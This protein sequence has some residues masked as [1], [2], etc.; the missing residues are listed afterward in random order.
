MTSK[1]GP[2]FADEHGTSVVCQLCQLIALRMSTETA[3]DLWL[4]LRLEMF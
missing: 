3:T 1:P 2:I 4:S